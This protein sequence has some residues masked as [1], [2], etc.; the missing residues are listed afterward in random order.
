MLLS[1][2]LSLSHTH[3]HTQLYSYSFELCSGPIRSFKLF[4]G[5]TSVLAT[6]RLLFAISHNDESNDC[7]VS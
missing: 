4:E 6:E 5:T 7:S 1:F 2:S 3:T